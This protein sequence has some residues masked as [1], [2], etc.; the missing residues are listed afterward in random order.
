MDKDLQSELRDCGETSA[1]MIIT[2]ISPTC[3]IFRDFA[4]FSAREIRSGGT[5]S[6]WGMIDTRDV[7]RKV[8]VPL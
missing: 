4:A 6:L 8:D 1:E 7:D 2:L 3:P 5:R